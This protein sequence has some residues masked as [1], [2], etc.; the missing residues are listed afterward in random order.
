[1]AIPFAL[2][3]SLLLPSAALAATDSPAASSGNGSNSVVAG[4][5]GG[6]VYVG[7]PIVMTA[8][9]REHLAEMYAT[10]L[11]LPGPK[12]VTADAV[13]ADAAKKGVSTELQAQVAA[14]SQSLMA[15]AATASAIQS[16]LIN[17]TQQPQIKG[18]YCGPAAGAEIITTPLF[19]SMKSKKDGSA[20]SQTTMANSNHMKT[21]ATGLTDWGSRNFANGLNA[22]TGNTKHVYAQVSA[23]S[24][25]TMVAALTTVTIGG[26]PV[27]A[28]TVE[29][30]NGSHY[31]NHP[32]RLIGH[33]II[34]YYYG[35]YGATVGWVD[36]TANSSAVSGF[37]SAQP[38]FQAD[39]ASFTTTYLQS[40]GIAY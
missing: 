28:D 15:P 11:S 38:K 37:G 7:P 32:N 33:W 36:S 30:A 29:F 35:N 6:D 17:V 27:A 34:T 26:V 12:A 40:N 22:W 13:R 8:F 4:G 16:S 1:M 31:N 14:K 3:G 20:I 5:T 25:A 24:A 21:D 19:G 10:Y 9:E 23:P 2:A 39:T 18:Y